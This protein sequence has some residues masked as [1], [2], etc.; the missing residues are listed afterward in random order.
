M[1]TPGI[2][3]KVKLDGEA[4]YPSLYIDREV[5]PGTPGFLSRYVPGCSSRYPSSSSRMTGAA[6]T[7][8]M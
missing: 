7:G 6:T 3:T 8:E 1:A 2:N 5:C 4:E